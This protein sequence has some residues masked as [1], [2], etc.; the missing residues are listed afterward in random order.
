MLVR[1]AASL[2]GEGKLRNIGH[3]PRRT[4]EGLERARV[5]VELSV[6]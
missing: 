2:V 5:G 4:S 1:R 3:G 6:S